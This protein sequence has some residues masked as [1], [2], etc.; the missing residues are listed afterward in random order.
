MKKPVFFFLLLFLYV[1]LCSYE[2][3]LNPE[4]F[5]YHPGDKINIRILSGEN[6]EGKTR[7]DKNQKIQSLTLYFGKVS[8]DLSD[9]ITPSSENSL[10]FTMVDEGT[11]LVAFH[12]T[13]SPVETEASRFN[14]YLQK[15]GLNEVT[16]YR[17]QHQETDSAGREY[18]QHCAKT[19]FQVGK[20]RD[21][22]F[23]TD[24]RLPVDIVPLY[25]PFSLKNGDSL[26]FRIVFRDA[27]LAGTLIKIWHHVNGKS[28]QYEKI[29]NQNGE[30]KFPVS[31]TGKWMISLVKME[32]RQPDDAAPYAVTE[33]QSYKA[34]LT[35]GYE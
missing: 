22:T 21:L 11:C 30:I 25:N 29:S 7:T 9:C 5:I 10:E 19:L 34:S 32:R 23:S 31:I 18:Y 8:D 6:F 16:E 2:L 33:W 26:A 27:P 1:I 35:W 24:T 20:K 12:S 3:W 14:E 13:H 15:E 17:K 28:T 4:K